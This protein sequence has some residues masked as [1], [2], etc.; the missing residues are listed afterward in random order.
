MG[1]PRIGLPKLAREP[2]YLQKED[3]ELV[4]KNGPAGASL[5]A[6][7]LGELRAG[8]LRVRQRPGPRNPLGGIKFVLPNSLDIYLHATPAQE[9][10]QRQ[11]RDFSHGCIRVAD[12]I[13]LAQFV[14][15]NPSEWT[16]ERIKEAMDAGK[17]ST[18][19]LTAPL[20]VVI[21]YTTAIVDYSGRVFF[22]PDVYGEDEKLASALRGRPAA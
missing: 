1:T 4:G 3:M 22:P 5:N 15:G 9:L 8:K 16:P 21:F 18:V 6:Q 17:T 2:S 20:P 10:F 19:K 11:R 13:A 14:L 12:P 7:T